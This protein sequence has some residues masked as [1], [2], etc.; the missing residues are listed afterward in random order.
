M[1]PLIPLSSG[2]MSSG[3]QSKSGQ[4]SLVLAEEYNCHQC[5]YQN[6]RN[7]ECVDQ[8]TGRVQNPEILC[9]DN[10]S[11]VGMVTICQSMAVV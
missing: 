1:G 4:P 2:D 6:T 8:E 10:S 9:Y 11:L 7:N 3:F 5:C